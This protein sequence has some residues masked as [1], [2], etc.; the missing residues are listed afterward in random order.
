LQT[1]QVNDIQLIAVQLCQQLE[2]LEIPHPQNAPFEVVT[3]SIGIGFVNAENLRHLNSIDQ[4]YEVAD[5]ALYRAKAAGRNAIEL[6]EWTPA[7]T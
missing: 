3:M 4:I 2:G 1:H 5:Q 6:T 7:N